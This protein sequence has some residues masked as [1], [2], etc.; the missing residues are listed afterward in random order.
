[1]IRVSQIVINNNL[2]CL[3]GHCDL[4][5]I[6]NSIK[7]TE[8]FW[9]IKT[10]SSLKVQI[11]IVWQFRCLTWYPIALLLLRIKL[12]TPYSRHLFFKKFYLGILHYSRQLIPKQMQFIIT[13]SISDFKTCHNFGIHSSDMALIIKA[14]HHET[15]TW[16]D[17]LLFSK[18]VSKGQ[19]S[20]ER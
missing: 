1:M 14:M 12:L 17:I 4:I 15:L 10:G 3:N 19:S 18:F 11:I 2:K 13:L 8:Y 20:N 5:T 9:E 16:K 7:Q 6:K